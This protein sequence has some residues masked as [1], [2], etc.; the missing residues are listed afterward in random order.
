MSEPE[1]GAIFSKRKALTPA[2]RKQLSRSRQTAEDVAK[3]QEQDK[4]HKQKVRAGEAD[5]VYTRRLLGDKLSKQKARAGEA[6]DER[7][8][9]LQ[10]DALSKQKARAGE[11]E[12][13]RARR[14]QADALR[15]RVAYGEEAAAKKENLSRFF[16]ACGEGDIDIVRTFIADADNDVN[17]VD[18]VSGN[19]ALFVACSS[20]HYDVVRDLIAAGADV[21]KCR[22]WYSDPC[23]HAAIRNGN[24]MVV[25]ELIEHGANV[26]NKYSRSG[27]NSYEPALLVA[28]WGSR[29]PAQLDII[30]LLLASGADV[31]AGG[32]CRK[33]CL[34]MAVDGGMIDLVRELIGR[35]ADVD[36]VT[37]KDALEVEAWRED[38]CPLWYACSGGH[39]DIVRL[40]LK[41][42][43]NP[44]AR[45][46]GI[47]L[48]CAVVNRAYVPGVV[49]L[50][51]GSFTRVKK[52]TA[53][54][55]TIEVMRELI[56][57]GVDVNAAEINIH[58]RGS[59]AE[60]GY[61]PLFYAKSLNSMQLLLD[62]GADVNACSWLLHIGT[63]DWTR[64]CM[65]VI[66]EEVDVVRELIRRG[67]NVD[68][69]CPLQRCC[70]F[71]TGNRSIIRRL[72]LEAGA[73]PNPPEPYHSYSLKYDCGLPLLSEVI[74]Y[75]HYI[76]SSF[77]DDVIRELVTAGADI[78]AV[79]TDMSGG[80]PRGW[81]TAVGWKPL[82]FY[83][84][85]PNRS[86]SIEAL[87]APAAAD[88][89]CTDP[90]EASGPTV[91]PESS[92]A[93]HEEE[94]EEDDDPL[95]L[96]AL[97]LS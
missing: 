6:E 8:R 80:K 78:H 44:N 48:L 10:A 74:T 24:I 39:L 11:A 15:H 29:S 5:D 66:D 13:E 49:K 93:K 82:Q 22:R 38:P 2:E 47:P 68:I 88:A 71:E 76:N 54:V 56:A 79:A 90:L 40:L 25:R 23:L 84:E 43:A 20:G 65:A 89:E 85:Q 41:A 45:T 91:L 95:S 26:N 51:A 16:K 87:L 63:R 36:G 17:C 75:P 31:N 97:S 73:N 14:L 37:T 59:A 50:T 33:T 52:L 21:H 58:P 86:A 30:H 4:V 92:T 46:S 81:S 83:A 42:G 96:A 62:N 94:E 35:G 28:S 57:A 64:L 55:F 69:G 3:T 9:R 70:H 53:D 32:D 34:S 72:L 1:P 7:A 67:A 61:T 27:A 18:A 19:T 77:R 60:S 12:A